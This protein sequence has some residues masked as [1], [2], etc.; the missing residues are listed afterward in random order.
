[1]ISPKKGFSFITKM[2]II[3]FIWEIQKG[4]NNKQNLLKNYKIIK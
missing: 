2:E 3:I 4:L 1:M